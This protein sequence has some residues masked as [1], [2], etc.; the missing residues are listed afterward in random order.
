VPIEDQELA[1][2]RLVREAYETSVRDES[3]LIRYVRCTRRLAD[4]FGL[5]LENGLNL[6]NICSDLRVRL[7][8]DM[9]FAAALTAATWLFRSRV[10]VQP[11]C[12]PSS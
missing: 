4:L 7:P 3:P 1:G 6:E 9:S 2:R 8:A 11:N 12:R 5:S 10:R